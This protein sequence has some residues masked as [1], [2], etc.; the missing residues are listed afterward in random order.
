MFKPRV[1]TAN[2]NPDEEPNIIP[3][4]HGATAETAIASTNPRISESP[5]S[6]TTLKIRTSSST[7]VLLQSL[8][9]TKSLIPPPLFATYPLNL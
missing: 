9:N 6:G 1:V 4:A 5:S 8:S 2:A 7:K 3:A